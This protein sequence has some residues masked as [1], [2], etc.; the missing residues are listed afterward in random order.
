MVAR[1]QVAL[2]SRMSGKINLMVPYMSYMILSVYTLTTA[3]GFL[4]STCLTT[5]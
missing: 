2:A 4:I 3:L 1:Q 5:I